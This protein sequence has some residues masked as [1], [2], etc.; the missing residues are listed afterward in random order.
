MEGGRGVSGAFRG[1]GNAAEVLDVAGSKSRSRWVWV[2]LGALWGVGVADANVLAQPESLED[3]QRYLAEG[4]TQRAMRLLRGLSE[5]PEVAEQVFVYLGAD[6]R[7]SRRLDEA[8]RWFERGLR[9]HPTSE[10]LLCELAM[11]LAWKGEHAEAIALYERALRIAPGSD[12]ARFGLARVLF[13][14]GAHRQALRHYEDLV[15]EQPESLEARLGRAELLRVRMRFA[16]AREAYRRILE[17]HP[18][19]EGAQAG[20]LEA[21]RGTRWNFRGELGVLRFEG[22]PT[23]LQGQLRLDLAHRPEFGIFVAYGVD[24][25]SFGEGDGQLRPGH[26]GTVGVLGR[27]GTVGYGVS[28]SLRAQGE[29]LQHRLGIEAS[30]KVAPEVVALARVRP[31]VASGRWALLADA[32]VQVLFGESWALLQVYGFG[33]QDESFRWTAVLSGFHRFSAAFGIRAGVSYGRWQQRER[34]GANA[35]LLWSP[36][37]RLRFEASYAVQHDQVFRH[38]LR[39]AV[40][41]AR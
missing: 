4:Q 11:T 22:G 32:G 29:Q 15:A 17:A 1:D 35:T 33:G 26:T 21:Q 20:L 40:V 41:V 38:D 37:R 24:L 2:L 34:P 3:A 9:R 10:A 39:L 30:V 6:A 27:Q 18:G 7:S 14:S 8:V 28:Y 36:N 23:L 12:V 5:A 25:P 13:W 19:H 16:E 31:S